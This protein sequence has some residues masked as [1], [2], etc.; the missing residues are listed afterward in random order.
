MQ[1]MN[2]ILITGGAGFIGSHLA[3]HLVNKGHRVTV[4]DD[5][6]N[7]N[8]DNLP[9]NIEFICGDVTDF[10]IGKYDVIYHLASVADYDKYIKYPLKT[11]DVNVAG[12]ENVLQ[13]ALKFGS[14]VYFT[15][16]SEI[17][18]SK[19]HSMSEKDYSNDVNPFSLRGAYTES[20]RMA[21]TLC[22]IYSQQGVDV[23]VFRL[24]NVY[25][26]GMIDRVIYSFAQRLKAD[27][28]VIIYGTG[29]QTRSFTFIKDAI[30]AMTLNLSSGNVYNIGNPEPVTINKLAEKIAL[31]LNKPLRIEYQPE[32]VD[33]PFSRIPAIDKISKYWQP[34]TNLDDGLKRMLL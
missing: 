7:G 4:L 5:L 13:T 3:S 16:S 8:A 6:S 30:K 15:S 10:L 26:K 27:L 2:K 18:G 14:K 33:D 31:I 25:G 24:F 19:K 9:E 34:E 20:K 12:T 28:P 21:E 11:F 29:E 1:Y 22:A 23:T 32:R 17:Y